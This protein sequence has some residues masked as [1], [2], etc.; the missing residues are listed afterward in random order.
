MAVWN[1][2]LVEHYRPGLTVEALQRTVLQVR[3]ACSS[4]EREGHAVRYVRTTIVPTNEAFLTLVEATSETL[5]R[6][7]LRALRRRLRPDLESRRR[8]RLTTNQQREGARMR[9]TI[10][11]TIA[12]VLAVALLTAAVSVAADKPSPARQIAALKGQIKQLR[13]ALARERTTV[14]S[15]RA[16]I[17]ADSPAG[18]KRLATTKALLDKYRSVDAARADGYVPAS[19]CKSSPAGSMGIHY[20][21]PGEAS[22]DPAIDPL[23]PE[24]MLYAP[25]AAGLE[26]VAAEYFKADADQD[27]NTNGDRPTLFGRAF[28]GPMAGHSPTMPRRYRPPRLALEAQPSGDVPQWNPDVRCSSARCGACPE[29]APARPRRACPLPFR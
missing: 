20:A 27:L 10:P 5:V 25:T 4:M 18:V 24:V 21:N 22:M 11:I 12:V 7:H 16:A 3:A 9:R 1:T 2:Y 23:K 28:D 13:V 14:A 17:A 19:P 15:L 29:M 6:E 8:R 26:L